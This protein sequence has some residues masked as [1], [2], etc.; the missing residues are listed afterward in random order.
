MLKKKFFAIEKQLY[1][2]KSEF[3]L[4]AENNSQPMNSLDSAEPHK[5]G[6]TTNMSHSV[7]L[8]LLFFN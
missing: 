7:L 2:E 3:V 6:N 1:D 4:P 5:E 8:L